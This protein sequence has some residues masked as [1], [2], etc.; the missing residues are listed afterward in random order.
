MDLRI[1]YSKAP[2]QQE[3]VTRGCWHWGDSAKIDITFHDKK[4]IEIA[5]SFIPYNV[6]YY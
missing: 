3:E 1:L 5:F 2:W 6:G 4:V